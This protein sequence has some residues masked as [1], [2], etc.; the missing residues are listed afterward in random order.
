M[1]KKKKKNLFLVV[2]WDSLI[3]Y[4]KYITEICPVIKDD[5]IEISNYIEIDVSIHLIND[6]LKIIE[7]YESCKQFKPIQ[8]DPFK[9]AIRNLYLFKAC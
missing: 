3:G 9:F 5:I 7:S 8:S 6:N 1:F 2:Y 4:E